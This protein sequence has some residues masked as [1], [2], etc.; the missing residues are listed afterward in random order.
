MTEITRGDYSEGLWSEVQTYQQWKQ[1]HRHDES[2]ISRAA[3]YEILSGYLQGRADD[4]PLGFVEVGFGSAIDFERCFKQWQKD[5][6]ISY[7]GYE[8]MP[9]FVR[10]ARKRHRGCDFREG[11]FLDLDP[12]AYDVAYTRHTLQHVNPD[13]YEPCLRALLGATRGLCV[14][15]WRMPPAEGHIASDWRSWQ[16][17][18]NRER[19]DALIREAGFDIE[20]REFPADVYGQEYAEGNSIYILKRR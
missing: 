12:L 3:A 1:F 13:L 17:T 6:A 5:G 9:Q 2:V 15:S 19:T 11:G 20:V 10:F 14:I 16:V 18:P 8:V 7:V 4:W